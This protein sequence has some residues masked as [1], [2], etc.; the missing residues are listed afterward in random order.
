MTQVVFNDLSLMLINKMCLILPG[1]FL[2]FAPKESIF[3]KLGNQ[4]NDHISKN[5]PKKR[6]T[7]H[8]QLKIEIV[9]FQ[10]L[11]FQK[12]EGQNGGMSNLLK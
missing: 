9:P 11:F 1:L 5:S 8:I 3:K 10:P 7:K 6:H 2:K 12:F 4:N